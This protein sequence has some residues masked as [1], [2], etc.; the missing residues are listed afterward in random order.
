MNNT[1]NSN[2]PAKNE[3]DYP[4][5]VLYI[6]SIV[7]ATVLIVFL[8]ISFIRYHRRVRNKM[9]YL[10]DYVEKNLHVK[11]E[12]IPGHVVSLNR[13]RISY[14]PE[15]IFPRDQTNNSKF[16]TGITLPEHSITIENESSI[17]LKKPRTPKSYFDNEGYEEDI[18]SNRFS[19]TRNFS[20]HGYCEVE[21][22][23]YAANDSDNE[24]QTSIPKSC[25]RIRVL[26][27][28]SAHDSGGVEIPVTYLCETCQN[29][30]KTKKLRRLISTDKEVFPD[31]ENKDRRS[32]RCAEEDDDAFQ[33][34]PKPSTHRP[35]TFHQEEPKTRKKSINSRTFPDARIRL[36][37]FE[38]EPR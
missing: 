10:R 32:S 24:S 5:A 19:R 30:L 8:G 34:S 25:E 13:P 17:Y 31:T 35:P 23:N 20:R 3:L 26:S 2:V 9:G 11:R 14:E 38:L 16:I 33:R 37:V 27:T 22:E 18:S 1:G 6:P 21:E 7:V 36:G 4:Q 29:H 15:Y 28:G 12:R